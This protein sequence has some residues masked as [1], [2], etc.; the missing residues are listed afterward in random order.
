ML[1]LYA[2]ADR[3]L[4]EG[5][6]LGMV[7]TQTLFQTR[8]AGDG[9]RRFRL[10]D[11]GTALGV[12]RVDD[13]VDVQPFETAANWT[14]TIVVEKG[15][16]TEYPV[17]YVRWSRPEGAV[18]C[19]ALPALRSQPLVAE[20]IDG[21]RAQSPWFVRPAD[22]SVGIDRLTGPS[23]YTA[24]LG[25]NSGGANGVYWLRVLGRQGELVEVENLP[26]RGK[27]AVDP[28][29]QCIEPDL[30]FPLIRWG[31]VERFEA[32]PSAWLLLA[33]DP[34]S[35]RGIGDDTLRAECPQ[36][37]AYL[38]RF[39]SLL[40]HRAAYRRYQDGAP[41]YSMYN[42]GS[43]TVASHKVVWRR[44]DRMVRAAVVAPVEDPLVGRRPVICQETC[45]LIATET[46]AEAHYLAALLNSAVI[47][48]LVQAHNVRG[49]K[50]FGSPGMLEY[51]RLRRFCPQ[52]RQ[53]AE[54]A[55]LS[56]EAHTLDAAARGPI[57][58]R[59]NTVAAGLYGLSPEEAR[60]LE[61]LLTDT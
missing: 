21:A 15:R 39:E 32:G 51:L 52:D 30:L 16:S 9:F 45:A 18:P 22:L 3:Y 19:P 54:L 58:Q 5:G 24:H 11:D 23:E 31:D 44:M 55:A 6:R 2:G 1:V 4:R 50:G 14:A 47:G 33:Q 46:A 56:L 48:F 20:P 37:F 29:R 34:E 42:V 25:A 43:Y 49:G 60:S 17:P 10:G 38:E 28:V 57:Q 41:F 8:G 12:L 40:R 53:H 7:V 35:R 61:S 59:I 27:Q 26:S 36:T 13:L